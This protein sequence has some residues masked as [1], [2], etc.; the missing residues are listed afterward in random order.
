MKQNTTSRYGIES[1][2]LI[3]LALCIALLLAWVVKITFF[4]NHSNSNTMS[5]LWLQPL[6]A[7]L[8]AMGIM[9]LDNSSGWQRVQ[10]V[11]HVTGLILMVWAANGLL[12]DFLKMAGLIGDP[13]TRIRATVN[14]P[15]A[16]MRMLAF[17]AAIFLARLLLT[18]S[19]VSRHHPWYGYAAFVLAL[20][21]PVLRVW[22]ALGGT[23]GI[24]HPGDAGEGFEPVIIAI[25]WMLAAVLSLLLASPP[26]WISRRLLLISGWSATAIVASIAPA[27]CW[28]MV[29]T[30]INGSQTSGD[31]I[32][33][34]V[35][36]LFYSSWFLW[37]IAAFAAT[38]SYQ[39]KS[40]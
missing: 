3:A 5:P 40:V 1:E 6:A 30:F 14:W 21:Y 22:W 32:A 27:A 38:R 15:D 4:Q 24:S 36:C 26:S 11:L 28:T 2:K 39:M 35:F 37:S 17:A 8:A 29:S 33:T 7:I 16:V 13:V 20:P 31:G 34:W 12:F 19:S 18:K 10:K 23:P 9:K 25:P